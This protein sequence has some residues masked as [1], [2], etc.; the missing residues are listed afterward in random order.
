MK[1][2]APLS[3]ALEDVGGEAKEMES[4]GYSGVFSFEGAH[5]PFMP[6]LLPPSRRRKSI[7]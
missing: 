2:D 7:S 1:E 6:R 3:A 5:D 4:L